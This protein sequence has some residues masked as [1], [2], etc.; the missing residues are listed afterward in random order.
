M[1]IFGN[2]EIFAIHCI[3]EESGLYQADI[4]VA[5][6]KITIFDNSHYFFTDTLQGEINKFVETVNWF[7]HDREMSNLSIEE[8]FLELLKEPFGHY[9]EVLKWGPPTQ[10]TWC[11]AVPFN[12]KLYLTFCF[13]NDVSTVYSCEFK[14]YNIAVTLNEALNYIETK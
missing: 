4:F 5:G 7:K 14:P 3:E 10:D 2:K 13:T 1:N 11:Y 6:H 9:Y 12:D 8:R